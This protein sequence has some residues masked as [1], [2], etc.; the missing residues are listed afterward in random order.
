MANSR[1]TLI[2]AIVGIVLLAGSW[3][4]P[5][6][7]SSQG[8]FTEADA[9]RYQQATIDLHKLAAQRKKSS[10]TA[11][12]NKDPQAIEDR[13]LDAQEQMNSLDAKLKN[14]Q[15]GGSTLAALLRWT[16]VAAVAVAAFGAYRSRA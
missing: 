2:V 9:V 8:S 13:I 7:V 11:T 14:A 16:G 5:A 10:R 1:S 4:W 3:L 12:N 15:N 6:V